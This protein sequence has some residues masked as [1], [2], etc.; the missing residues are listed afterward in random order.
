MHQVSL[1]IIF[2]SYSQAFIC[3]ILAPKSIY[4]VTEP[5]AF[6]NHSQGF[7]I[8]HYKFNIIPTDDP[9]VDS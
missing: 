6:Y 5:L 1:N 2:L 9:T 4:R 3:D 8:C 7:N